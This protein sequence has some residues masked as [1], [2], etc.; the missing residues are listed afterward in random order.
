MPSIEASGYP[1]VFKMPSGILQPPITAG[2]LDDGMVATRVHVR[3]LEGMQK[4]AV[5]TTASAAGERTWRLVSDVI[6]KCQNMSSK[7]RRKANEF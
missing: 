3:A 5:V 1:L 2:D 6:K 4:E 7:K